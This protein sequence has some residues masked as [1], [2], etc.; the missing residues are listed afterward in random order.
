VLH[1]EFQGGTAPGCFGPAPDV[2][3]GELFGWE[4]FM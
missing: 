1:A 2:H 4:L 3:G